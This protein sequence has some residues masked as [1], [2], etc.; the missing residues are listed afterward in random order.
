[1]PVATVGGRVSLTRRDRPRVALQGPSGPCRYLDMA[2]TLERD[3]SVLTMM[4][5]E[6]KIGNSGRALADL[7]RHIDQG[8]VTEVRVGFDE[9]AWQSG[10]AEHALTA[11]E[12][13]LANIGIALRVA[14]TDER[15]L[16]SK[17]RL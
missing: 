17:R 16:E 15:L 7:Q 9:A 12:R 2:Y 8:G 4:V 1:M 6:P 10:W 3:G 13:S 11:L 14:G 5:T